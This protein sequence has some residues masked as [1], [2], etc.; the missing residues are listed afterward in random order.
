M[1]KRNYEV[2]S[3]EFKMSAINQYQQ[4]GMTIKA[5]AESIGVKPQ[6]FYVWLRKYIKANNNNT[7][8]NRLIEITSL[9]KTATPISS[10]MNHLSIKGVE[11]DV[12]DK[13]LLKIVRE[14]RSW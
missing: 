7:S 1:G 5:F 10:S 9:V 12:D 6:T 3:A 8:P 2:Y 4:S 11:L 13:A 14:L